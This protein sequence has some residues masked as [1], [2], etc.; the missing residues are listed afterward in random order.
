MQQVL[1]LNKKV[2]ET[3]LETINRFKEEDPE[4]LNIK[5]TYAGRLDPMAEGVLIVLAGD[6]VHKKDEFLKLPK[7]Y[8]CVAILGIETDT[9]DVLGISTPQSC[10]ASQL[11]FAGEQSAPEKISEILNSFVGTFSQSY[12][13]YSSKTVGG[14]QLH[15]IAREGG[16]G[17]IDLPKH[18]VT[19]K[20][21]SSICTTSVSVDDLVSEIIENVKKVTGDFRQEE[22]MRK[23]EQIASDYKGL[24][25]QLVSFSIE[26][27]GGT[28][29]RG[30]VHELGK[31]LGGGA[32]ILRLKRTK[33]G[34]LKILDK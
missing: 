23:W 31:K 20:D 29:I 30:V 19:V 8:E 11:S 15:T 16:L 25:V 9:Y 24:S 18:R 13:P 3:P 2:G 26:V 4:Y 7:T 14:K 34:E 12:P 21:I 22:T 10:F 1:I 17:S 33:V 32:C 5:M 6:M 28:Y 27:S